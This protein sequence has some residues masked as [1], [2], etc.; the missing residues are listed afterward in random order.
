MKRLIAVLCAA[1]LL[2]LSVSALAEVPQFRNS[3]FSDGKNALVYLASGEYE[4]LVTLLPFSGVSPSASE[5]QDFAEGN[6]STL[7]NG[8]QTDY[9]VAYWNGTDWKLAIPVSEPNDDSV[10]V[11]VLISSDGSTFDGYRYATWGDVRQE[12]ESASYTTWNQE[13]V[14]GDPVVTSD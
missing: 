11:L 1:I 6:F 12:Y 3:L 7:G 13:Y 9:A 10:E 5:W 8:V 2:A 14:S 4:R